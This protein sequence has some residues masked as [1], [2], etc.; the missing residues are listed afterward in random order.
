MTKLWSLTQ[1]INTINTYKV[2]GKYVSGSPALDGSDISLSGYTIAGSFS[3]VSATDTTNVAFGKLEYKIDDID[4]KYFAKSGG[5]VTG[6]ITVANSFIKSGATNSDI[7][8][9][10]GGTIP[11]ATFASSSHTHTIGN[12]TDLQTD[13]DGKSP[14]S[15]THTFDS[16]TSKPTTLSGYG[17]TDAVNTTT[18]NTHTSTTSGSVSHITSDERTAWNNKFDSSGGTINGTITAD[19]LNISGF[20]NLIGKDV[21][22]EI[23]SVTGSTNISKTF[24]V[25]GNI[26]F[27]NITHDLKNNSAKTLYNIPDKYKPIKDYYY[28]DTMH[29]TGYT[30]SYYK[31]L[32]IKTDGD[33]TVPDCNFDDTMITIAGTY[34][35]DI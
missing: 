26:M 16:L 13:L 27:F 25:L 34:I 17:I 18:F 19:S 31:T 33:I 3:P 2:N 30:S 28:S 15:H 7:L 22:N 32:I 1:S 21:S 14:T 4:G 23:T 8:L 20:G 6:S 9:G 24:I 29:G 11:T 12:I 5:T 35:I 10:A